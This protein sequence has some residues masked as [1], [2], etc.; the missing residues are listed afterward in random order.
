MVCD[1]AD[2][3]WGYDVLRMVEDYPMIDEPD[4]DPWSQDNPREDYP[5]EPPL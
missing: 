3:V 5:E 1:W 4:Q 2:S